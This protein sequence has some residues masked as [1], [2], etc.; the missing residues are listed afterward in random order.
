MI[1]RKLNQITSLLS[2][3]EVSPRNKR[4]LVADLLHNN[5]FFSIYHLKYELKLSGSENM[6]ITLASISLKVFKIQQDTYMS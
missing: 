5:P 6:R 4:E 3:P 1:I 2:F